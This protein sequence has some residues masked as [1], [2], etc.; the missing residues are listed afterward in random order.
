MAERAV[1]SQLPLAAVV[2][3][4]RVVW[5]PNLVNSI[6]SCYLKYIKVLSIKCTSKGFDKSTSF[7]FQ[8]HYFSM[9]KFCPAIVLSWHP[10]ENICI[11]SSTRPWQ[12]LLIC[13]DQRFSGVVVSVS[14][15]F[16]RVEIVSI[17]SK[18]IEQLLL[19]GKCHQML[20]LNLESKPKVRK[21]YNNRYTSLAPVSLSYLIQ[22]KLGWRK[23]HKGFADSS[24]RKRI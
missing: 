17:E 14:F 6:F 7:I 2:W 3:N 21:P 23:E 18:V 5:A 13:S 8:S 24:T 22:N 1:P 16:L 9:R 10:H 20:R 11:C 19:P 12:I 15:R 4:A